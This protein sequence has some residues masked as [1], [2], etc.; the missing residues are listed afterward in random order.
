MEKITTKKWTGKLIGELREAF[1]MNQKEFAEV[2]GFVQ[3]QISRWESTNSKLN[4]TTC[5]AMDHIEEYLKK[6]FKG[7][8]T[9]K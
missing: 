6:F 9:K 2:T 8:E 1:G 3:P 5:L 4:Y 7:K